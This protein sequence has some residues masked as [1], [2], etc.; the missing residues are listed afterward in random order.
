MD[1]GPLDN[2]EGGRVVVRETT[3]GSTAFYSCLEGFNL[4]GPT[5]RVCQANGQWSAFAPTCRGVMV[6]YKADIRLH[7]TIIPSYTCKSY[8]QGARGFQTSAMEGLTSVGEQ[9]GPPPPTAA[10]RALY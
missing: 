5:S 6:A 1:C 9:W 2:P 4:V 3:F 8:L 7:I 10:T